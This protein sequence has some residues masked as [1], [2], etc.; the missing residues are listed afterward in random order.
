MPILKALSRP[1]IGVTVDALLS[2]SLQ[3][4]TIGGIQSSKDL[5]G[6]VSRLRA[7]TL[8]IYPFPDTAR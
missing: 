3:S 4:L 6:R 5:V 8:I 2:A 1:D 7:D